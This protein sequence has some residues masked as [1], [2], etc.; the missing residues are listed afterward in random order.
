MKIWFSVHKKINIFTPTSKKDVNTWKYE[1]ILL[2]E[3]L[4]FFHITSPSTVNSK[5]IK[6]KYQT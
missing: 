5:N 6:S 1:N 2:Q 3:A 4:T